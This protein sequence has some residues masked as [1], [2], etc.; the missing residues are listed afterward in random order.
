MAC[1]DKETIVKK[2]IEFT[3]EKD[4]TVST[5]IGASLTEGLTATYDG[6]KLKVNVIDDGGYSGG[7][8]GKITVTYSA[9]FGEIKEKF[10]RDVIVNYYGISLETLGAKAPSGALV[11]TFRNTVPIQT[12]NEWSRYVVGGHNPTWNRFE[13][14]AGL[15]MLGSDTDG[16]K[17]EF[18]IEDDNPNTIIYNRFTFDKNAQKM[19]FYLS[20]NP[21]PDYN[22]LRAKYRFRVLDLN[23]QI[24][25]SLQEWTEI[26]APIPTSGAIDTTWYTT[27]QKNTYVD[28]D[29]S[30]YAGKEVIFFIEQDSSTEVYQKEFYK[31]LGY[32]NKEA[33]DFIKETRDALVIYDVIIYD[34]S[35]IIDGLKTTDWSGME[36]DD[37]NKWN[38]NSVVNLTSTHHKWEYIDYAKDSVVD[39]TNNGVIIT[40]QNNPNLSLTYYNKFYMMGDKVKVTLGGTS[41][42][43]RAILP[44]RDIITLTDWIND[45]EVTLDFSSY[46]SQVITL[47]I[48][49]KGGNLKIDKIEI[50]NENANVMW[51]IGDSVFHIAY[52]V[53][54][55]IAAGMKSSLVTTNLSGTTISP[56]RMV[57]NSMVNLIKNGSF[58]RLFDNDI[59]PTIILIQR[60]INDLYEYAVNHSIQMGD[61]NST[62]NENTILGAVNYC[63][64]YLKN[65]FPNARIVWASPYYSAAIPEEAIKEYSPLLK[66]VCENKGIEF[67]NIYENLGI[68]KDNYSMY[69]YDGTH[70]NSEGNKLIVKCWLNYLVKKD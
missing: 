26:D 7:K 40:T 69:L 5:G 38:F 8:L 43:I 14:S 25:E 47:L 21:Y 48:D 3:N 11:W 1:N 30:K 19:R 24:V 17:S 63:I 68:N 55:E 59:E 39:N 58:E 18:E 27:M 36:V 22:N 23:T 35:E 29:V 45:S 4:L 51:T 60:G 16:R 41:Y 66:K 6:N 61:I 64:D 33:N 31:G 65:R 50:V 57:E 37:S 46:V 52:E 62:D 67:L 12:G 2:S 20:A 49:V 56:C 42:R 44:S 54:A 53:V 34:E 13:D 32:S 9:S 15:V 28:L 70:A 10:T